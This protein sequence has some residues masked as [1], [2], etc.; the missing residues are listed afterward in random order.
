MLWEAARGSGHLGP[1]PASGCCEQSQDS[2]HTL[3]LTKG[4]SETGLNAGSLIRGC[5][6]HV[7]WSLSQP[8]PALETKGALVAASGNPSV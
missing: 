6:I 1:R 8:A 5:R 2:G 3:F 7:V 4:A